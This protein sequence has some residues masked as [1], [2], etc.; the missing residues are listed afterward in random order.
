VSGTPPRFWLGTHHPGWVR[1]TGVPLF[2]S[3]S[4]LRGY[5][6]LPKSLGE[7]AIDSSGFMALKNTGRYQVSARRYA[8]E[9]VRWS[10]ELGMVSWAAVQDWMC[11]PAVIK[12]GTFMGGHFAGT[13]LSVAEHQRRT[14]ESYLELTSVAPGVRWLPVLQGYKAHEYLACLR[15]YEDQGVSLRKAPLVG[16]GSVCRRQATGEVER[17][18]K[19]LC[20]LGVKVHSFDSMAWSYLAR[21]SGPL[22]GHAARHKNC[23]NC[24]DFALMWREDIIKATSS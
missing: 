14:V 1:K 3:A 23:A 17:L 8:D 2:L 11:E 6:R 18:I 24:L 15:L 22:P 13:G 19:L 5:K 10:D 12:G 16:L 20:A 21:R 9:V 4:R 7:V